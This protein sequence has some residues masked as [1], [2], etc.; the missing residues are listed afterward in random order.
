MV[1]T[2]TSQQ[3]GPAW[4]QIH[5]LAGAFLFGVCILH[6]FSPSVYRDEGSGVRLT[7]NL[8]LP[9]DVM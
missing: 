3:E 2:V 4:V 7:S 1:S 9:I 5:P 6:R 8:K